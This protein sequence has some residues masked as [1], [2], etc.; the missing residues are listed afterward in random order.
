MKPVLIACA[1]V[2][3]AVVACGC[4]SGGATGPAAPPFDPFGIDTAPPTG[5]EPTISGTDEQPG[6]GGQSIPQ[7]CAT[8]CARIAATACAGNAGSDCVGSCNAA[9][10]SV[11][12]GCKTQFQAY[13]VCLSTAQLVCDTGNLSAPSCSGAVL[14]VNNCVNQGNGGSL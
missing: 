7:L 4:S 12:S 10:A 13:L 11:P 5:A 8:I 14:A 2:V 3:W 9:V 1:L 6:N